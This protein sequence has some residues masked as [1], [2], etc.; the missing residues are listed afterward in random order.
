MRIAFGKTALA[1]FMIAVLCLTAACSSDNKS[2]ASVASAFS[3][4]A[5]QSV[6]S[7]AAAES[8]APSPAVTEGPGATPKPVA[9][10]QPDRA[11]A[12]AATGKVTAVRLID[13]KAG[14]VGGEGWIART[15][16]GGKTWKEQYRK[17]TS[18]VKQIFAL[19]GKEAWAVLEEAGGF[20]LIH[21]T[22]GGAKW[23]DTGKVPNGGFLHFRSASEGFAGDAYTADGG[24]TWTKLQ[25][26]KGIAGT[27]Y[28]HDRQIGWAAAGADGKL[29]VKRT[30]DGGKTWQT[31][32]SRDTAEAPTDAVIR[33]AGP[34]DAWVEAV[35]GSG[36]SQTAYSLFHTGNGGK[37]WT[38]VLANS[39]A[40]GGIAPGFTAYEQNAAKNKGSKPGDLYVVDTKTAFMSGYCPACDK[41]NTVG[42]T[43]DGGKTWKTSDAEF[44]GF[45]GS[46]LAMAD[47]RR[48][49]WI[50][51]DSQEPSVMYTTTDGGVHWAKAHAFDKPKT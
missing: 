49:W 33:S 4:G 24:K 50:T 32:L 14:W 12:E 15:D 46:Y 21:T 29:L 7:S 40:G 5:G 31:V 41:S 35:G 44:P 11:A 28:F 45:S 30:A 51:A 10:G 48:G 34:D 23:A 9:V 27:A 37:D 16:D 22:D 38:V 3:P 26:P 6:P 39:N 18:A 19:N 13:P 25:V 47:A 8:P 36:M 17:G 42:W 1:A 2:Q 43:T 20:G